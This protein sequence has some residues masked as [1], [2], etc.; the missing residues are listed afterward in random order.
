[1]KP[2]PEQPKPRGLPLNLLQGVPDATAATLRAARLAAGLTLDQAA[3][4]MG[5]AGRQSVAKME[6]GPGT[7]RVRLALLLLA[8]GQHPTHKALPLE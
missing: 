2:S 7:E 6:S 8:T 3:A 5:L 4:A 1:M